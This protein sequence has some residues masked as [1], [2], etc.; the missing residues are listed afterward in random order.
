VTVKTGIMVFRMMNIVDHTGESDLFNGLLGECSRTSNTAKVI[1]LNDMTY[2]FG[3]RYVQEK[4]CLPG[5]CV[6]LLHGICDILN[7]P[8][9]DAQRLTGVAGSGKSAV[10]HKIARLYDGHKRLDSSY[11]NL[12]LQYRCHEVKPPKS[13][14]HYHI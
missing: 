10:A 7:N 1:D 14:Q 6:S 12:L 9:K 2:A 3:A 11:C 8:D 4:G 5:T 13:V